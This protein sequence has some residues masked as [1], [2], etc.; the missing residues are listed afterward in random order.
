MLA[1][2]GAYHYLYEPFNPTS[3]VGRDVC[4]VPFTRY[5]TYISPDDESLYYRPLRDL[6]RGRY[7]WWRALPAARSRA[8]L[9]RIW[10]TYREF[11]RHRRNG[12]QP[13]I[14][15]PIA[16]VSAEWLASRF[17]LDVVIMVRHPAAFVSSMRRMGWGFA[18]R[19]WALSQ[20]ALMRDFLEPYRAEL[21][22]LDANGG[23]LIAQTS[24][25][26]KVLNYMVMKYQERHPNWLFVR[27]EDVSADPI[28]GFAA[29][30]GRLGLDFH[31]GIRATIEGYSNESNPEQAEGSVNTIKL[32]SKR[33]IMGWRKRLT[34]DEVARIREC[35]EPISSH[36]YNDAEWHDR[37]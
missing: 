7:R 24:L 26:W 28:S 33:N 20:P 6:V 10:R 35:V 3:G 27:H 12:I 1:E 4:D 22:D 17:D 23:D 34:P 2:S 31:D 37:A 18:P 29:L 13:L 5:F 15:D 14:K 16:L 11:E 8:D 9:A 19:N 21:E 36:F 30:Y 25:V 32:N